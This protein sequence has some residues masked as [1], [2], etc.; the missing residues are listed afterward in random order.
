MSKLQKLNILD[1]IEMIRKI[2]KSSM[3]SFCV[4]APK[5]YEEAAKIARKFSC[6][7]PKPQKIIVAGMGGSAIGGELLKDFVRDRLAVPIEVEREYGLPAHA[8]KNT[9]VLVLSY[10]GETE[11][12]LSVF[13]DAVK[14]KCMIACVSSDGKL[15]EYAEKFGLPHIRI[16]YGF[17]PRA[18]LP[19]LF[20][21]LLILLEKTGLISNVN[22]EVSEA[23][24][25]LE[26]VCSEN[27]PEKPSKINFSKSLALKINGT[28]PVVYGFG[29]YRA[30][31]Q[32]FKQQFNENSK[33]PSKWETFP[34]LNH[35]EIVGW[36]KAQR[37]AK[38]FSAIF[39]RDKEEPKEIR[40]RI[41]AT[42]ELML[43]KKVKA[44]EVW[45]SG[46]SRLAKMLSTTCIGD[47]TSV[48]LASLRKVDPTPVKTI[49]I[50]K[51]KMKQS[52]VKEKILKELQKLVEK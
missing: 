15:L 1:D 47:F 16:P 13:L 27:S 20:T 41:E 44:F 9:L 51:E 14:K 36:E 38:N 28:V 37:L 21:P 46:K 22:A 42:K 40:E 5:H 30:V 50:L 49:A 34:E 4:D 39:I 33:I 2:D 32:R 45:S 18:A 23:V 19:Y 35:N 17:P 26:K 3:L 24:K 43:E 52:G 7:Y 6:N 29:F 11:E 48:Y 10:S 8:D 12:T 31:A 25:T